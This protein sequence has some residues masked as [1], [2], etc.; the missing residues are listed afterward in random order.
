MTQ[1]AAH[2]SPDALL[3][4]WPGMVPEMLGCVFTGDLALAKLFH[5]LGMLHPLGS[6]ELPAIVVQELMRGLECGALVSVNK[7]MVA[8]NGL[9][10]AGRKREEI[11]FAVA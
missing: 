5:H 1:T 4:K 2:G 3:V 11:L 9:G 7:G 8:G 10:V 6:E